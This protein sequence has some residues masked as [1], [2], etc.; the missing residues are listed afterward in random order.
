LPCDSLTDPSRSLPT[1]VLLFVSTFVLSISEAFDYDMLFNNLSNFRVFTDFVCFAATQ[2]TLP[3]SL[4]TF[5]L[6]FV[7][8]FV[9]SISEA[10]DYDMLF[11]NLSNFRV[12][13]KFAHSEN[14]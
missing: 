12:S 3:R 14:P 5:A 9:S 7:S 2:P 13:I 10:L 6:L 11:N 8:T 1:F 4:S